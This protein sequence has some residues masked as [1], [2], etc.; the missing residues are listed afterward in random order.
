MHLRSIWTY[1]PEQGVYCSYG[2]T[3]SDARRALNMCR[4]GNY[5]R[6]PTHVTATH[7]WAVAFDSNPFI[8]TESEHNSTDLPGNFSNEFF[9]RTKVNVIDMVI[10]MYNT[11]GDYS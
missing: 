10:Y 1:G 7:N 6:A 11:W 8:W 2:R 9:V 4:H 5:N 3:A